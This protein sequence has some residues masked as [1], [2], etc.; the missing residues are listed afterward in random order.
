MTHFSSSRWPRWGP[1]HLWSPIA[2]L[3]PEPRSA[4]T[5]VVSFCPTTLNNA[6]LGGE[7]V[8][9]TS[10]IDFCVYQ[11][12]KLIN[13]NFMFVFCCQESAKKKKKVRYVPTFFLSLKLREKKNCFLFFNVNANLDFLNIY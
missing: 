6:Y 11:I 12:W 3:P 7:R 1:L 10:K 5:I 13:F 2:C 8:R 9:E 4:K